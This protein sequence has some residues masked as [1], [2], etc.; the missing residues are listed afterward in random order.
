MIIAS[1]NF[2]FI[3]RQLIIHQSQESKMA[4]KRKIIERKSVLQQQPITK[5]ISVV[6]SDGRSMQKR[7]HLVR[8]KQTRDMDYLKSDLTNSLRPTLGK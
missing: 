4:D 6:E 1:F 5:W 3:G 7:R 8:F 2:I